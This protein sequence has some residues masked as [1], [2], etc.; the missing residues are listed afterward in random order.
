MD[1]SRCEIQALNLRKKV[2]G[3]E[4]YGRYSIQDLSFESKKSSK[5][6]FKERYLG[7]DSGN[8]IDS[9]RTMFEII[10]VSVRFHNLKDSSL[11]T[12]ILPIRFF[13]SDP[14]EHCWLTQDWIRSISLGCYFN[15]DNYSYLYALVTLIKR[16]FVLYSSQPIKST[17]ITI[18]TVVG[19][20]LLY[21]R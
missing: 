13:F 3:F 11:R 20:R 1:G 5:R 2:F 18:Y 4:G 12:C 17:L 6:T 14:V 16:L 21:R 8:V 19:L 7:S 10:L 15:L 9:L